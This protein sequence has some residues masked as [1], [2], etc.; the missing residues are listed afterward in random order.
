ME[1]GNPFQMKIKITHKRRCTILPRSVRKGGRRE[2]MVILDDDRTAP[3]LAKAR[4]NGPPAD[5]DDEAAR[6]GLRS[7]SCFQITN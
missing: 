2:S 3:V 4:K 5:S 7:R 1:R 6:S